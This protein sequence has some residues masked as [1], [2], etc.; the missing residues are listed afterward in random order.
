MN[1][2]N[3][4]YSTLQDIGAELKRQHFPNLYSLPYNR[5]KLSESQHWWLSPT[6]NKRA[7]PYGKTILTCDNTWVPTDEIFCG[8]NVE[9]GL[10]H[11]LAQPESCIMVKH[12]F[13]H[14]FVELASNPLA[15]RVQA[16][17]DAT[18]QSIQ[19]VVCAGELV[20]A[21]H[22]ARVQLDVAGSALS[23]A[24]HVE[25][26][27]SLDGI[28]KATDFREFANQLSDINNKSTNFQWI[29]VL[30]GCYFTQDIDGDDNLDVCEALIRPFE[31][32]MKP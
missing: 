29:D 13:W 4:P 12:W 28:A 14:R 8:F 31:S 5:F 24:D 21:A 3:L 22:W 9:K 7:F 32:W 10:T 25:G 16:A 6:G 26:N 30:V 1:K 2:P 27:G 15:E 18:G 23:L 20:P 19:V 17:A 11:K